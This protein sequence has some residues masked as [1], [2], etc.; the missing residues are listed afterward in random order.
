LHHQAAGAR[1]DHAERPQRQQRE[2]LHILA[3]LAGIGGRRERTDQAFEQHPDDRSRSDRGVLVGQV[4]PRNRRTDAQLDL[5]RERPAASEAQPVD[6][7]VDRF[8]A[9]RPG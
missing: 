4:P 6:R 8:P 5:G 2:R 9:H 7:G 1:V 3:R